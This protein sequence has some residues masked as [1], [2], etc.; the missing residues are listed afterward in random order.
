MKPKIPGMSQ[1]QK[2]AQARASLVRL[3]EVQ[4][5]LRQRTRLMQLSTQRSSLLT[6]APIRGISIVR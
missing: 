1:D 5:E 6:G 3:Q 4:D 2:D